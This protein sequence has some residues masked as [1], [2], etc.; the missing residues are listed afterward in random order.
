MF[1]DNNILNI[2]AVAAQDNSIIKQELITYTPYTSSLA[3]SE[4]IRF[5]IQNQ[6][7]Y[8]LPSQ[9]YLYM[10]I[11][12]KTENAD[13][14]ETDKI[15]FVRNFPSFLFSDASYHLNS[16]EIDRNRNV[17]VTSTIKLLTSSC[18]ANTVGYYHFNKS[19]ADQEAENKNK[20]IVYDVM[21]PLTIWFG[22]CDDYRRVVLNSRHELILNRARTDLNCIYGGKDT[23][24][25]ANVKISLTRI[26]W[27]MPHIT[28]NDD[29]RL[30]IRNNYL[31]RN[32]RIA[33]QFRSWELYEYPELP[34]TTNQVWS[35]KTVSHLNKPRYVFVAFQTDKKD[36]KTANA[37]KFETMTIDNVRLY[38][39]SN[40]Y[41]YH[42]HD[43]NLACGRYSELYEAYANIQSSYYNDVEGK[44]LFTNTYGAFQKDTIFAF[45]TS[46]ADESLTN[47]S[48]D[49][50]L[51]IKANKNI[52][53]KTTAF[54]L[55]IYENDFIHT[56]NDALV[57]RVVA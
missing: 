35:V 25:S 34:P 33:L 57:M 13:A 6:D 20:E 42:M 38:L 56:L 2:G 10:Q 19:F 31:T 49:I 29:L 14:K 50:K 3:E 16:V 43:V 54:C 36:K 5:L 12:V 40:V 8:L 46:R 18:L 7:S 32:K 22:F 55:I 28:L 11:T 21:L 17:G 23:A 24:N 27:K 51:D 30:A 39:N 9:S 41:P 37:S 48:I 45:D 15:K 53:P 1:A 44:N 52:E 47:G 26:E 4:E